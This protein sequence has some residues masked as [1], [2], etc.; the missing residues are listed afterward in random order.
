ML[1]YSLLFLRKI[2]L[3][4][5]NSKSNFGTNYINENK[6]DYTNDLISKIIE[7]KSPSM[8]SRFGATESLNISNYLGVL[9]CNPSFLNFITGKTPPWW[10]VQKYID[11]LLNWS[12]VFPNDIDTVSKFSKIILNDS[13]LIDVLGSW[14]KEEFFFENY[15]SNNIKVGIYDLEPFF[16]Q[17]PWTK[18]LEGKKVLVVHPFEK[19]IIKQYKKR[20]KIF[21]NGFLPQF[22]LITLKSVQSLGGN[23]QF[24]DW[25]QALDYMKNKIS[26]IDFDIALIGAGAYGMPLAAHVKRM[27]K[28]GFH[29]GGVLQLIFGISGNRWEKDKTKNH[30]KLINKHWIKPHVS[31][32]SNNANSV[33]DA[34]YW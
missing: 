30:Y 22:E 9:S 7:T 20:D 21:Y 28:V 13:I 26:E 5:D 33:E 17:N 24:I 8:I 12:G 2:Y 1:K 18:S 29:L 34:C 15:L 10:W 27:G 6:I 16:S 4:F 23:T 3:K 32:M 19:S 11:Q 31:E 25:F 14:R